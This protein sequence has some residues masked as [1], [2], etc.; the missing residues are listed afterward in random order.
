MSPP[1]LP[2]GN[3]YCTSVKEL[4]P[5]ITPVLCDPLARNDERKREALARLFDRLGEAKHL[6]VHPNPQVIA[7]IEALAKI[8][9]VSPETHPI[10]RAKRA[11][12]ALIEEARQAVITLSGPHLKRIFDGALKD[13]AH[14]Q[15]VPTFSK[16]SPEALAL[17]ALTPAERGEALLHA[18]RVLN[19]AT[20]CGSHPSNTVW[21]DGKYTG[22]RKAD[23]PRIRDYPSGAHAGL[24]LVD[25]FQHLARK[26]IEL[27]EDMQVELLQLLRSGVA[28][29]LCNRSRS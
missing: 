11:N 8:I 15:Y 13:N 4:I 21:P 5:S 2:V 20:H 3:P 9:G 28:S 14:G 26:K 24:S 1:S 16:G 17:D 19:F 6:T 22:F 25:L 18:L 10:V 7:L 12:D 27:N 23:Y 29:N